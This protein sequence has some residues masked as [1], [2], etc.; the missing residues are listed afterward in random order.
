MCQYSTGVMSLSTRALSWVV[1]V[2]A[3][4]WQVLSRLVTAICSYWSGVGVA[5]ATIVTARA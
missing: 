5:L 2:C 4:V 1:S 3:V